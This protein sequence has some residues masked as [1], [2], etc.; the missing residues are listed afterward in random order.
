MTDA[1]TRGVIQDLP[2][3]DLSHAATAEDLAHI[4][5]I[6]DVA[7]VVVPEH[8]TTAL[9]RIPMRE[10]ASVIPV[11][12]GA[13]VRTHTGSL[14]IGGDGLADPGGDNEALVVTGALI[15]TSP[16]ERVGF[17]Q[18]FVTGLVLAPRG[19]E[20][21]VGTALT[22]VTGSV[23]YYDLADGQE[24]REFNGVTTVSGATMA[25][26]GGTPDDVLLVNGQLLVTDPVPAEAG[27]F[28][29]IIVNGAVL[30]PRESEPV[31]APR[32]TVNGQ[33]GWYS[34]KPR[35]LVGNETYGQGFFE[36]LGANEEL[37]FVGDAVLDDDVSAETVRNK[38]AKITLLG[39]LRAPR[40]VVPVL[41]VLATE[42]YGE[43]AVSG[44]GGG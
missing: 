10:V 12:K 1:Q 26:P 31:L 16:V 13:R 4:R 40:E 36:L 42:K 37:A 39:S 24:F 25:N 3:L 5:L 22:R 34:G 2:L 43:I 19:S 11:A 21:A 17:R 41:Q 30:A 6:E 18:I 14:R 7:V 33:V 35:F 29:H 23:I 9:T 15:V 8:L 32:L 27:R 38:V 28:Q 20:S 44:D